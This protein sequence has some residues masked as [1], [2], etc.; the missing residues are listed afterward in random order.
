[1]KSDRELMYVRK[2]V[3]LLDSLTQAERDRCLEYILRRFVRK[4]DPRDA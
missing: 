2:I 1:M 3:A 4:E